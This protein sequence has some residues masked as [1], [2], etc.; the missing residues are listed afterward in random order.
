MRLPIGGSEVLLLILKLLAII[1][2]NLILL[3]QSAQF[4]AIFIRFKIR[5]FKKMAPYVLVQIA[6]LSECQ[7]AIELLAVWALEG[8]FLR[9]N[10]QVVVEVVPLPEIHWA[11]WVVAL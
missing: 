6:F 7:V 8:P 1:L 3:M 5:S 9:V 4:V 10:P 11:A 2:L